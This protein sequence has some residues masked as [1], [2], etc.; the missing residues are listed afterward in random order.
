MINGISDPLLFSGFVAID[1]ADIK[2]IFIRG[3]FTPFVSVT[4]VGVE[5]GKRVGEL[6]AAELKA[7]AVD[8]AAEMNLF[9]SMFVDANSTLDEVSDATKYVAE[10]NNSKGGISFSTVFSMQELR[11]S[12]IDGLTLSIYVSEFHRDYL[13]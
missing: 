3:G 11:K 7:C 13:H 5:R 8:M 6:A 9:L 12:L 1:F 10:M 4:A 2:S